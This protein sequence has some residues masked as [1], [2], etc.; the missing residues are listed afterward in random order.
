[1]I[2]TKDNMHA[3]MTIALFPST[4]FYKIIDYIVVHRYEVT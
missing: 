3:K 2:L 1:M 4:Q